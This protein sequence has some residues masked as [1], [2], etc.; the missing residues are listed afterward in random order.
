MRK[1]ILLTILVGLSLV[2]PS[3]AVTVMKA[4]G[5][6]DCYA[7][8]SDGRIV[9]IDVGPGNAQG[10]VDLLSSGYLHY[11]RIVITHVHSD[12]AGGL[13]PAA[14]YA[15]ET[16]SALSTDVLVSNH[17]VH[18]LDLIVKDQKISDLLKAMRGK[19]AVV[20]LT[21]EALSKGALDDP[22]VRVEV[23]SLTPGVQQN[24]NRSG[25]VVKVTEIRDGDSRATLFLGDIEASQQ[26]ALFDS[27]EAS[28]IFENVRAV[29][30]PHHGRKTTLSPDFFRRLKEATGSEVV[31]LHSDLA[32]LDPEV[33]VWAREAGFKVRSTAP[34]TKGASTSDIYVN[35][36]DKPTYFVVKQPT[37]INALSSQRTTL[38][39]PVPE[40]VTDQ[41]LA[42]AIA[43]FNKRGSTDALATG[44]VVNLP[45]SS[46]IGSYSNT[47]RLQLISDLQSNNAATREAAIRSLSALGKNLSREQVERLVEVMRT[48]NE[49]VNETSWRGPHCTHYERTAAKV[50]A[51]R[52]VASLNSP[53][54]TEAERSEAAR[55]QGSGITQARIDDPGWI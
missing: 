8:I 15:N 30:L 52:I 17:G 47:V 46:S 33:Q 26:Q 34:S 4:V 54:V 35:L 25:L 38:S 55:A 51:G 12:H 22:N 42:G 27:P 49:V 32:A 21:E 16:G 39:L 31:I 20:A 19:T 50:Y 2:P 14:R 36:Y 1:L 37:T 13:I 11:D 7:V 45:T 5:H 23:I 6:G 3:Q 9:V 28:K 44:Y 29:T 24:E 18:D 41:E 53:Y 43:A 10:L 48:G 40:G